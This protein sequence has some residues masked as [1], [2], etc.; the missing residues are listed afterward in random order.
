MK[1]HFNC[2]WWGEYIISDSALREHIERYIQ[3]ESFQHIR[4]VIG[5]VTNLYFLHRF[6]GYD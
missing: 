5:M 1:T 4:T 3:K 2:D 6:E